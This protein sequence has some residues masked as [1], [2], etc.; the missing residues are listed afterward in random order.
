MVKTTW[1]TGEDTVVAGVGAEAAG[2]TSNLFAPHGPELPS[3][4]CRRD[5]SGEQPWC[6]CA[7]LDPCLDVS[8]LVDLGFFGDFVL[9]V[10]LR[11]CVPWWLTLEISFLCPTSSFPES[12]SRF[13]LDPAG[14]VPFPSST[15]GHR[16]LLLV[17]LNRPVQHGLLAG[18]QLGL[19]RNSVV[20]FLQ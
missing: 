14:A 3:S 7:C 4:P 18:V 8:H 11:S 2:S 16:H 6:L 17:L 13:P 9:G 12:P 19:W 1:E 15:Q 5:R 20:C 10:G